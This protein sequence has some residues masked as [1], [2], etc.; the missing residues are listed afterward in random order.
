MQCLYVFSGIDCSQITGYEEDGRRNDHYNCKACALGRLS[1]EPSEESGIL[2]ESMRPGQ[3]A[4]PDHAAC[5][6]VTSD[7]LT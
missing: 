6:A 4:A 7:I 2:G 5:V 1:M 3:S